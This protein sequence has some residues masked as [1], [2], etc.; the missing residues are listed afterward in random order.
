[1]ICA[2][3]SI[4]SQN[5]IVPPGLYMAD[6]TA[7]VWDD[8]RLYIYGSVDESVDYYCS[9]RYHVLSTGDLARWTLHEN[10]FSSKGVGD[11][12]DYS[13]ALLFAPDCVVK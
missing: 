7:K 4:L 9:Y 1:L 11:Q 6:P 12:V 3:V 5:P 2:S 13:D 8:G 10:S